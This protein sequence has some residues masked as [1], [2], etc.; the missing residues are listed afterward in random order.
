MAQTTVCNDFEK[1]RK[2]AG[3][4]SILAEMNEGVLRADM[5]AAIAPHYPPASGADGLPPVGL[6]RM[7]YVRCL[8]GWFDLSDT[9]VEDALYDS[10]AMRSL[11]RIDLGREPVPEETTSMRFRHLL[12][13][14]RLEAKVFEEVGR[15]LQRR[16]LHLSKSAILEI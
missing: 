16:G 14:Y 9:T 4:D 10:R 3:R 8:P 1:Y 11:L 12:E 7:P 5:V 6:E 2:L 13:Q 15:V